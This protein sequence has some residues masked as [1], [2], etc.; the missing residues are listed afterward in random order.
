[1]YQYAPALERYLGRYPLAAAPEI[2][3]VLFWSTDA[4]AGLRPTLTI[5]H[6]VVYSPP[7]LPG[8]TLIALKQL[9]SNHYTDGRLVLTAVVEQD[10][11]GDAAPGLYLLVV[12][13]LHFDALPSGGLANVRGGVIGK[14]RGSTLS[15]LRE[16]RTGSVR[17]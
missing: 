11:P 9:Y 3:E 15:R 7:E 17:A 6:E 14:L 10:A 1:M 5:D 4:L 13:R 12:Q 8:C 2:R 16:A